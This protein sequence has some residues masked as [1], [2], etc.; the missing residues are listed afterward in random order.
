MWNF[1]VQ[2]YPFLDIKLHFWVV[3]CQNRCSTQKIMFWKSY[4]QREHEIFFRLLSIIY[5][6]RFFIQIICCD[7]V[8]TQRIISSF[9][10]FWRLVKKN[11][12]VYN[13]ICKDLYEFISQNGYFSKISTLEYRQDCK[14]LE[15]QNERSN[16]F[17][18]MSEFSSGFVDIGGEK[19]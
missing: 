15:V 2:K 11:V 14:F 1:K 6:V 18:V 9:G 3:F 5:W 10:Y 19:T 8:I 7:M 13:Q 17:A 4:H 16:F 12:F